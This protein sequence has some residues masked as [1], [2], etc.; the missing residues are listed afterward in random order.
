MGT[1]APHFDPT[2]YDEGLGRVQF[3][4]FARDLAARLPSLPPGDLLEIAAGTGILTQPLRERLDPSLTLVATDLN[5]AMLAYARSKLAG[6]VGI[7]WREA[8]MTA[9]PFEDSRFGAVACGF[10]FMFAPDRQQALR[11]AR[12]VLRRGGVLLFNVWDRIEDNPHAYANAQAVEARF[13]G[14]PQMKFRTPYEMHEPAMLRA[15]LAGASLREVKIETRRIPIQ[16]AD[17]RSIAAGAVLG[18]P[19]AALLASRG[20]DPREMVDEVARALAAQ[21][22]E[23]YHGHA[24]AVVVETVA[25]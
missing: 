23:P 6:M 17:P 7:A 9:L 19:R 3:A 11:E 5:A 12:R 8:D 24:Q 25:A 20:V 21:G 13:P 15:L 18:T 4:P 16:G 2:F 1:C 10:G 22:G 14:D